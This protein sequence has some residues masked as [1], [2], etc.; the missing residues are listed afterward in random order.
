MTATIDHTSTHQP[1]LTGSGSNLADT[2]SVFMLS[3]F[4]SSTGMLHPARSLVVCQSACH[5]HCSQI[6]P[7]LDLGQST[8]VDV[9]LAAVPYQGSKQ[10]KAQEQ[11]HSIS[12][13]ECK[14]E[15]RMN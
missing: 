1:A 7:S 15:Y 10:N 14:G 3:I 13:V 9:E 2:T 6:T 12:D 5:F 8:Q 11:R 4:Q